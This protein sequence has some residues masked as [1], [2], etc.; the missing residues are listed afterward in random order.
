MLPLSNGQRDRI[1]RDD[2]QPDDLQRDCLQLARIAISCATGLL[3]AFTANSS[4]G[5]EKESEAQADSIAVYQ[6]SSQTIRT[7]FEQ[8]LK[9]HCDPPTRQQL[10][11]DFL[12]RYMRQ[13]DHRPAHELSE[14]L[15]AM[16][17]VDAL[18][19]FLDAK[20]EPLGLYS[21]DLA[22]HKVV[23]VLDEIVGPVNIVPSREVNVSKQ[24]EANR[25]VGI[26]IQLTHDMGLPRVTSVFETGTSYAAGLRG[27]DFIMTVDDQPTTGVPLGTVVQWLRGPEGSHVELGIKTP[28]SEKLK[29]MRVERKVVPINTVK[30]LPGSASVA[31]FQILRIASSNVDELTGLLEILPPA[32]EKVVIDFRTLQ[33]GQGEV[34]NGL[35]NTHLLADA[36]LEHVTLGQLETARGLQTLTSDPGTILQGRELIL[37]YS[38]GAS[39]C[40]DWLVTAAHGMGIRVYRQSMELNAAGEPLNGQQRDEIQPFAHRLET[41]DGAKLLGFVELDANSMLLLPTSRLLYDRSAVRSGPIG[42]PITAGVLPSL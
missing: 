4:I 32:I 10:I 31:I 35:H 15:S 19:Q 23:R 39:A 25:Y 36:I 24:L 38:P 22:L 14:Q 40:I 12:K 41:E 28:T 20:L 1:L 33:D 7:I 34:V 9:H 16:S 21:R 42:K 26:G 27:G 13:E 11:A 17:D 29:P 2:L 5:Q 18:Y 37:V 30:Q 8:V 6:L 3:L